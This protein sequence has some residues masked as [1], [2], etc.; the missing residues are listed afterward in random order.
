MAYQVGPKGQ[1]VVAKEIRDK[2]GVKPG[3][4]AIQRLEADEVVFR[5]LPPGHRESLRGVLAPF[6]KRR[7]PAGRAWNLAKDRAWALEVKERVAR[8]RKT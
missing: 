3:W 6:I 7:I 5:F 2:L 4:T 8:W 1:V